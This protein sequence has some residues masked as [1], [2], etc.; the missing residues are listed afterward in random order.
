MIAIFNSVCYSLFNKNNKLVIPLHDAS[1]QQI[2]EYLKRYRRQMFQS[3]NFEFQQRAFDF[4][5]FGLTL[6]QAKDEIKTLKHI[7]YD[8]GP[9]LDHNGD[10]TEIWEFGKP[11][12]DPN[13]LAYIKIKM[14]KEGFCKCLS[15][16]PSNGPFTLP[17]R[18]W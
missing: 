13:Q 9:T 1:P 8:R 12:D 7:H 3:D 15:F 17:Y 5:Q 16:K 14:T 4:M 18:N 10:G 2:N 11:I 6:E